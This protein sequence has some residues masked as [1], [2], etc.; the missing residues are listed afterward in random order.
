MV[1]RP[2]ESFPSDLERRGYITQGRLEVGTSCLLIQQLWTCLV[3]SRDTA[4]D[5]EAVS[6]E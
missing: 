5:A 2:E 3:P 6:T 1:L 4:Q